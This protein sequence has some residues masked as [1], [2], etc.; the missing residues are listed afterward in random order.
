MSFFQKLNNHNIHLLASQI[1]ASGGKAEASIDSIID[2]IAHLT[3]TGKSYDGEIKHFIRL[4][5]RRALASLCDEGRIVFKVEPSSIKW[6]KD[7]EAVSLG[8]YLYLITPDGKERII[9]SFACGGCARSDVYAA[10]DRTTPQRE[11]Y[12]LSMAS[13]RAESN[14]YYNAGIGIEYKNNDIFDL[15]AMEMEIPAPAPTMPETKSVEERKTRGRKKKT[16]AAAEAAKPEESEQPKAEEN[17][18]AA[19]E[20]QAEASESANSEVVET[21]SLAENTTPTDVAD[22][23]K[24]TYDEAINSILDN[25]QYKGQ[26]IA[27]VLSDPRTARNVVWVY[28]HEPQEG[29]DPKF[30]EAL[31]VAL[32]GYNG[33][34][35]RNYLKR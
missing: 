13:A 18:P 12:M 11:A 28:A 5:V 7:D 17:T 31:E 19:P 33:G 23:G 35:L 20:A 10:E 32:D 14:A 2:N 22:T 21:P 27:V 29:R 15:E 16:E 34:I 9:S 1:I 25:G 30:K 6:M 24:L 4:D 8:G 26:T 3:E